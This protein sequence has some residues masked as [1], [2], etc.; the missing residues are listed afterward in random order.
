MM[1]TW[2]HFLL[3]RKPWKE[4][5][6]SRPARNIVLF[7]FAR[8]S[9]ARCITSGE[10]FVTSGTAIGVP[11]IVCN[12]WKASPRLPPFLLSSFF[13]LCLF[14]LFG[15]YL[16]AYSDW[17]MSIVSQYQST[18]WTSLD[19]QET[20]RTHLCLIL[21]FGL[22]FRLWD[23][24]GWECLKMRPLYYPAGSLWYFSQMSFSPSLVKKMVIF[25]F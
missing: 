7:H 17:F 21:Y 24:D 13:F 8:V 22:H 5:R 9:Q 14:L 15:L 2:V 25:R 10:G 12:N 3:L 18:K 1:A 20:W 11:V 23:T 16:L 4:S 19:F 6:A